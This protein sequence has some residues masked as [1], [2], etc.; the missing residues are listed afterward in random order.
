MECGEEG[1]LGEICEDEKKSV[2][3]CGE[4]G[5]WKKTGSEERPEEGMA[6][7]V[8]YSLDELK[9]SGY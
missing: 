2:D 9:E 5:D 6:D 4:E 8:D 7:K 3:E 1:Y